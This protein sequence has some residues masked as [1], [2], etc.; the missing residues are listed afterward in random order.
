M[1]TSN[2]VPRFLI[3]QKIDDKDEVVI[4]DQDINHQL[5]NV[6]RLKEPDPIVLLDGFGRVFHGKAKVLSKKESVFAEEKTESFSKD[7]KR[8]IHIVPSLLKHN[9]VEL[10]LQKCTEIGVDAFHPIISE[11]TEKVNLNLDRAKKIIK[12]AFEQSE[13]VFMPEIDETKTLEEFLSE[14]FSEGKEGS[15]KVFALDFN[16]ESFK[17]S[18]FKKMTGEIYFLAGPEGGWG[19]KDLE[20][21]EKYGIKKIT[22]GPQILRAETASISAS[23]LMLLGE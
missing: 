22:L 10:V 18:E 9:N 21:F 11:R 12:E 20:L 1:K 17:I 6:L 15:K 19:E 16:S 5:I 2:R 7:N 14:N 23:A 13:K 3:N 8:I 4:T